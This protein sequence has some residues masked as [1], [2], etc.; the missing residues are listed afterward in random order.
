MSK[1]EYQRAWRARQGASTGRPGPAP[2]APCGTVSAYK[3]HL[4]AAERPCQPCRDAWSAYH[5]ERRNGP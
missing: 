4:R 2:S 5:R 3:R 1:A